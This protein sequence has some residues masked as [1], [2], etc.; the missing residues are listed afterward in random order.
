MR[1]GTPTLYDPAPAAPRREPGGFTLI[2]LLVVIAI[3]A[4]L[5]GMLLPALS[6]AKGS[7]QRI[8][9]VNRLKQWGLALALYAE[10]NHDRLPRES[11][12]GSAMLNN[13]AQV[14]DPNN[15]DVWYNALPRAIGLRPAADYFTN[16]A[17][18]HARDSFGQCPVAKFPKDAL[19][20][21]ANFPLFSIA[22]NS[23]LING[24]EPTVKVSAIQRPS[25]TVVFLENRL[26]DEPKV[27]P[28]QADNNLGQ[29]SSFANRFVARHGGTG[30]L[31]FADGHVETL[32]GP[33]VV[34]TRAGN[35]N[36]GRAILP[37]ER[38]VWTLDP[39]TNPN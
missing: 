12:G 29:P 2:E 25:Q 16:R 30:N 17:A 24:G 19:T 26:P 39:E 31:V 8:S 18:F 9:C 33:L 22:M 34:E 6:R 14:R 37:Q 32:K 35:A 11:F 1:P 38:I 7:A 36:R 23:K 20:P 21:T 13:W 5:A 3:I 15:H 28:A 10:D 4:I 27:D